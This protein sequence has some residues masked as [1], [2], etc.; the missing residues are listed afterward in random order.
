MEQNDQNPLKAAR[1][2]MPSYFH[3]INSSESH[4]L[5]DWMF[6][7][8]VITADPSL[9]ALTETYRKRLAISKKFADELKPS[10]PAITTSAMMD[11][12]GRK[13][14]N[15]VKPTYMLQLDFDHVNTEDMERLLAVVRDDPHTMVEYVTVSGRGFRIFCSYSRF[16]DDD[17][18]VLEL[19]DVMLRK[20]MDHYTRLLGVAP[21][22]QCSDITRCAGLAHDAD[23]FFRWEAIPFELDIPDLK[24]L[25][26]QKAIET[27]TSRRTARKKT[28]PAKKG[29]AAAQTYGP[30]AMDEAAAHIG[31]L[32][33]QWGYVF[34]PGRHNEYVYNFANTCLRYGIA[35]DE[36][37]Q[38]ATAEYG[39]AY[40]DTAAVIKSCY[41]HT[42]RMGVWHFYQE[43][44]GYGG[45]LSVKVI[46]QW[47]TT[48]YDFRRNV[49]TG[50]YEIMSRMVLKGKYP[51]W[52]G[53]DDNISNSLWSEMNEQ[54]LNVPEK[55]LHSI[56]NSDFSEAFDPLDFYLRSLKPWVKGKDPD[57]IGML[58]D[59]IVVADLPDDCHTQELFRYFFKKWLVAMVVAWVKVS[60]VN[61]TILILVGRG[62][63]MKT[64]FFAMLLPP[65]L[66]QYF[67]NDSTGAY[68]DKDFMEAFS[69]KALICLDEFETVFGKNLSAFKSNITKTTFSIRR[70]YDKYRSELPHRGALGGTTNSRQF[71]TDEEN[72]RYSPWIVES[73]LSPID[74]PIDYDNVYAQAVA[75]GKEVAAHPK[76]TEPLWTYW[77]TRNDIELMR[78]HNRLF[79][80]ANYAEEQILRFYKVPD[81]TT[82]PGCIRFRYSAE[83]LERI[84]GNPALRQNL[85]NQNIGA[86]MSRLGF[87]KVH[88]KDGNGW[89][90]IEKES[91]EIINDA[92]LTSGEIEQLIMHDS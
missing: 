8:Q 16:A 14:A 34:E 5:T 69:S 50:F 74:H 65:Q 59:R 47:L 76:G 53:I 25:Y 84:G 30:P 9:K 6:L 22:K 42:E 46:K 18:T 45:R 85:N 41:K 92:T 12:S 28:A 36:V 78:R 79:M 77:L 60:V 55:T 88:K 35:V 82:N 86:V 71:I 68:T 38:Y 67:I 24:I 75:L 19:F 23:A 58:A 11:G 32:L 27:K 21:D 56:I 70:P 26:S 87:K 61:Q 44:E 57:Y 4:Q 39:S 43:G 80:V 29:A 33:A 48:H 72:R 7:K 1:G 31:Q 90:V 3:S 91:M 49:M 52:T 20:A 13:L 62:G 83:I 54:G 17:V 15:F 2:A 89:A 64:T 40:A 66:R 81:S 51:H 73:I 37:M 63:I 10:F